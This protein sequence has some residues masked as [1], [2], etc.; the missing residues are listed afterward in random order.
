MMPLRRRR[1]GSHREAPLGQPTAAYLWQRASQGVPKMVISPIYDAFACRI[2]RRKSGPEIEKRRNTTYILMARS[3]NS[4]CCGIKRLTALPFMPYVH[5]FEVISCSCCTWQI[6]SFSSSLPSSSLWLLSSSDRI[7]VLLL[8]S[9][10]RILV[11]RLHTLRYVQ[12][13]NFGSKDT[14]GTGGAAAATQKTSLAPPWRK[15]S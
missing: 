15:A 11:L 1:R 3:Y 14:S 9:F 8:P 10:L 5:V 13:Y 6:N 2:D 7:W 4:I 12:R